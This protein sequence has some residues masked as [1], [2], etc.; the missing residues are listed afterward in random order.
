MTKRRKNPGKVLAT[1]VD[2]RELLMGALEC[3]VYEIVNR[4][5]R[6]ETISKAEDAYQTRLEEMYNR[7]A[8]L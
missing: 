5:R 8:D 6:G 3:A 1:T 7:I 4:R 2:D